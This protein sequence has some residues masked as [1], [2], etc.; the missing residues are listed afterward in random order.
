M[1]LT[2]VILTKD[3]EI[4]IGRAIGSVA[5]VADRIVVVD[6]GSSDETTSI[7]RELGARVLVHPFVTQAK[8]FNWAL[9]QLPSDTDWVF[10]LDA[11]EIVSPELASSLAT[12]LPQ[13]GEEVAGV[14]VLRR[15]AFLGRPIRWGGVFPLPIVRVLRH[16]RGRSEDR[17][18]DEHIVVDGTLSRIE[19]ELLDD[20][21]KPLGWWIEKHNAYASREV[22]E[23]LDA[24]FG[25]LER[26]LRGGQHGHNT[27]VKR[28]L[29]EGLYGRLPSGI[30]SFAYFLYR[31]LFR[32]G[33]LD[34]REGTAFH[35]L[36]GFWYRFLVDAKLL[37][38][39]KRMQRDGLDP[40]TAVDQVLDI[41]L[42]K[43]GPDRT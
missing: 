20:N 38:V 19:G 11:D 3:E 41:R 26:D 5:S 25:F 17:W 24:E 29:K 1:T 31:Y 23:I 27:G 2:V 12:V 7:A 13:L 21:L 18:M 39:R 8:Q 4:H 15:M 28:W 37:E 30:R 22:V 32:F 33:F 16:G 42:V 14:E 10:R 36:Q 9:E 35:V 40:L 6:S 43:D 34:G